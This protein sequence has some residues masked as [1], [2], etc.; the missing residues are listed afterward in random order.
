[1]GGAL[2][3]N[4]SVAVGYVECELAAIYFTLEY[5][6][7]VFGIQLSPPIQECGYGAVIMVSDMSFPTPP[8]TLGFYA[9]TNMLVRTYRRL[10]GTPSLCAPC[11]AGA[12]NTDNDA[13]GR[14]SKREVSPIKQ[15]SE[16]NRGRSGLAWNPSACTVCA[17]TPTLLQ[18]DRPDTQ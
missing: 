15:L 7:V 11:L 14:W 1:M 2:P 12:S 18:R 6:N 9:Y 8:D 13:R 4:M 5:L 3:R 16:A 10:Y 17:L